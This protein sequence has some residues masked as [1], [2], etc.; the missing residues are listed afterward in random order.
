MTEERGL[1]WY[2][3]RREGNPDKYPCVGSA[4]FEKMLFD[5]QGWEILRCSIQH[6]RRK[7]LLLLFW[8]FDGNMFITGF[9]LSLIRDLNVI[10][11]IYAIYVHAWVKSLFCCEYFILVLFVLHGNEILL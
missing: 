8:S 1:S 11:V 9:G 2:L 4:I 3:L 5:V 10:S 6:R 7:M